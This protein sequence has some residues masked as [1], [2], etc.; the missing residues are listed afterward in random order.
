MKRKQ[1]KEV[2]NFSEGELT[3][4]LDELQKKKF[5]SILR[6]KTAP[7]K[8]PLE[9]RELRRDVARVKTLL[10]LKFNKKV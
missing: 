8:N 9:I 7:L 2:S 3:A 5:T 6:H 10:R 4:K 1:F